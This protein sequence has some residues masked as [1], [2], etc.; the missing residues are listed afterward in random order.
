MSYAIA[1]SAEQRLKLDTFV[2]ECRKR[3]ESGDA[4]SVKDYHKYLVDM[5]GNES[6]Q[7]IIERTGHL[8]VPIAVE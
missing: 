7:K 3:Y 4:E 2:S 8:F 6:A 5:L 1:I